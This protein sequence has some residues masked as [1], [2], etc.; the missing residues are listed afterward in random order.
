MNENMNE[1]SLLGVLFASW[2][3]MR[4]ADRITRRLVSALGRIGVIRLIGNI[5]KGLEEMIEKSWT[6]L[7]CI[8]LVSDH[9]HRLLVLHSAPLGRLRLGGFL[10]LAS[11]LRRILPVRVYRVL[12]IL[13]LVRFS[14]CSDV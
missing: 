6:I 11:P 1:T 9:R 13:D 2:D 3:A 7:M 12:Q 4:T 14:F 10:L 8:L 5:T